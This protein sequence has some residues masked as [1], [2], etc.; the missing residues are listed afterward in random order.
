MDL[1]TAP[2]E[3]VASAFGLGSSLRGERVLHPDGQAFTGVVVVSG[4]NWG[5]RLLDDSRRH[6]V[7]VRLSRSI[8]LPKPLPD[9]GGL[10]IRF[11]GEG[12]N[13]AALDVLMATTG[14][15]PGLRHVLVPESDTYSTLFPYRT[16]TGRHVVLGARPAA[17]R[18]W[19][20]LVGSLTGAWRPWGSLQLG[21]P[22]P[23][24]E[25]EHLRFMPTIAADDLRHQRLFRVLRERSYRKSQANRP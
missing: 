10:A 14:S 3:A 12:S 4:G 22:L 19:D 17:E 13:G 16:G 23:P 18:R 21:S 8:G 6:D 24:P 15:A 1:L 2:R 25:S 20:L 9:I 5:A 7:V 11:P